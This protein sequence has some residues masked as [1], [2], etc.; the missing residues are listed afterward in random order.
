LSKLKKIITKQEISNLRFLSNDGK[1]SIYQ[2]RSGALLYSTNYKVTELL[3]TSPGTQ[4]TIY[5]SPARKK[6]IIEEKTNFFTT[7][8]IRSQNKIYIMNFDGT[9]LKLMGKGQRPQLH[10]SDT[11]FSIYDF[12]TKEISFFDIS[13]ET[14][15]FGIKIKNIFSPY[16][17]PHVYMSSKETV[18]YTDINE[19]GTQAILEFDRKTKLI[20][21][22]YKPVDGQAGFD[23]CSNDEGL[24]VSSTHPSGKDGK[25]TIYYITKE[26][27]F[28]DQAKII[29]DEPGLLFG[30]IVCDYKP[31]TIYFAFFQD[32]SSNQ[33]HSEV[34]SLSLGDKSKKLV[35]DL[36]S[37]TNVLNIDGRLVT[38]LQGNFYLL[39]G[40]NN[41]FDD[42]L[43][44]PPS[45]IADDPFKDRNTEINA[46][47][48]TNP[49]SDSKSSEQGKSDNV[50]KKQ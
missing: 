13:N 11:W 49:G 21:P 7:F 36:V 44:N 14:I 43:N 34:Y 41:I 26:R 31:G 1:F 3:Q 22:W 17:I 6:I 30:K 19:E 46:E 10:L 25:T 18:L 16:F 40:T 2:R 48:K 9:D 50:D 35:S 33:S 24:F 29:L 20:K 23:F 4:F 45:S 47:D 5:A 32:K 12:N 8:N 42:S 37:A 39:D 28:F 27:L 38:F 15:K